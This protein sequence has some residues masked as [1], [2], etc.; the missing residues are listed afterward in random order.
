MDLVIRDTAYNELYTAAAHDDTRSL[1]GLLQHRRFPRHALN[2]AFHDAVAAGALQSLLLLLACHGVPWS[3]GV[4]LLLDYDDE[5][6]FLMCC[7]SAW[8]QTPPDCLR[9]NDSGGHVQPIVAKS[10]HA[11]AKPSPT[12]TE[13]FKAFPHHRLPQRHAAPSSPKLLHEA[14]VPTVGGPA[15]ATPANAAC[16]YYNTRLSFNAAMTTAFHLIQCGYVA[17]LQAWLRHYHCPLSMWPPS[18]RYRALL[19]A[20]RC[21]A[22]DDDVAMLQAVLAAL[23]AGERDYPHSPC[24]ASGSSRLL[25]MTLPRLRH[26]ASAER[27]RP[28]HILEAA[29][30]LAVPLPRFCVLVQDYALHL[31]ATLRCPRRQHN[32]LQLQ[33]WHLL[34][35]ALLQ[36]VSYFHAIMAQPRICHYLSHAVAHHAGVLLRHSLALHALDA[37]LQTA[38]LV[39]YAEALWS[40][41]PVPRIKRVLSVMELHRRHNLGKAPEHHAP[42][43]TYDAPQYQAFVAALLQ[44]NILSV[45]DIMQL[46]IADDDTT[47]P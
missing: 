39:Q 24:P 25:T 6:L 30:R 42:H 23:P 27:R 2:T 46:D 43:T 18:V 19:E 22:P 15:T 45:T 4:R 10:A 9:S 14:H 11:I 12:H 40:R 26:N 7:R 34:Q 32:A 20:A 29:L 31:P 1:S 33:A 28:V 3:R 16:T 37:E 21:D 8:S 44:H 36:P 38:L 47:R 5:A 41:T 13:F 17:A 35:A